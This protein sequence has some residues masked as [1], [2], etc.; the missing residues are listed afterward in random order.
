MSSREEEEEE[1][2]VYLGEEVFHMLLVRHITGD[3]DA[4]TYPA[5][6]FR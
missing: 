2:G 1:E 3:W 4:T 6:R 5:H